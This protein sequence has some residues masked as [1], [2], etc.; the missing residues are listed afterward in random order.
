MAN[1]APPN[2]PR[3]RMEAN[4]RFDLPDFDSLQ[5]LVDEAVQRQLAP[6]MGMGGGL[7]TAV[8][9]TLTDDGVNYWAAPSTF[10]Y[11]WCFRN[12]LAAGDTDYRSFRSGFGLFDKGNPNQVL[13]FDY[14]AARALAAAG[15]AAFAYPFLYVQP[16]VLDGESDGRRKWVAGAEQ[17][18]VVKTRR[19][20][21]TDYKWS[22]LSPSADANNGW[23]PVAKITAWANGLVANPGAP[24]ITPIPFWDS[25]S[26]SAV[27]LTDTSWWSDANKLSTAAGLK[28]I[29]N[30]VA[31][32]DWNDLDGSQT[33]EKTFGLID[34]LTQVRARF[35]RHLDASGAAALQWYR[36]PTRDM[37][38]LDTDLAAAEL[39]L[40]TL[41]TFLDDGPKPWAQ[42]TIYYNGVDYDDRGLVGPGVTWGKSKRVGGATMMG[43]GWIDVAVTQPPV[44]YSI[45]AVHVTPLSAGVIFDVSAV[46]YVLN[47]A[48]GPFWGARINLTHSSTGNAMDATFNLSVFITKD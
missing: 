36:D 21:V 10:Q 42:A 5:E 39:S 29:A 45:S 44:G 40:S 24:T 46:A 12:T 9:F 23:A 30:G 22:L 14:T 25:Y 18:A 19:L 28:A 35:R 6:L 27:A 8:S 15:G 31:N 48:P 37:E 47:N 34:M 11:Y 33:L 16:K 32:A 7:A 3:T 41:E 43:Q 20:L 2:M 4:E 17:S 26:A 1:T 13:K 38:V